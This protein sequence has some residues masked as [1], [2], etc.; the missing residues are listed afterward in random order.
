MM[1]I[2]KIQKFWPVSLPK[3]SSFNYSKSYCL[4]MMHGFMQAK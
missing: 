3:K 1:P 4:L 2:S